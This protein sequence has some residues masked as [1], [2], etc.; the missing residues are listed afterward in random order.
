M[1]GCKK[2]KPRDFYYPCKN[3]TWP[4]YNK[5][6]FHIPVTTENREYDISLYANFTQEYPYENLDFNMVLNTPNGEERIMEYGLKKIVPGEENVVALK[7]GLHI[8]KKGIL[9][10]EI[11]NLMPVLNLNGIS[12]IGIRL[13]EAG[14]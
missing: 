6:T 7:K 11:E 2:E 9:S 1:T 10:L 8:G 4:R 5:I 13:T 12:G 3:Q 14:K